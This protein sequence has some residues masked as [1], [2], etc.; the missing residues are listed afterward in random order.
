MK[1][2][3]KQWRIFS[4]YAYSDME[5]RFEKMAA[6]GWMLTKITNQ[7]FYYEKAEPAKVKFTVTYFAKASDF[8][9]EIT[10]EQKDFNDFCAAAGWE[11]VSGV[12]QMQV[13]CNRNENPVPIETDPVVQVNAIHRAMKK[14]FIPS[15]ILILVLSIFVIASQIGRIRINPV[16]AL[17]DNSTLFASVMY[18]FMAVTAVTDPYRYLVWYKKARKR[19]EDGVWCTSA[20]SS[21]PLQFVVLAL[22]LTV[23]VIYFTS[24]FTHFRPVFL[25]TIFAI[26][27]SVSFVTLFIK[28]FLKKL[29]VSRYANMILTF[30]V[31]VVYAFV[32]M[33]FLVGY[34]LKNDVPITTDESQPVGT[35]TYMTMEWDLYRDRLPLYVED[36]LTPQQ[37]NYTE[38]SCRMQTDESVFLAIYNDRHHT[39]ADYSGDAPEISYEI[40]K[41]K[42]D[43]LYDMCFDY[44]YSD[45][46]LPYG[47]NVERSLQPQLVE[48]DTA[49]WQAEKAYRTVYDGEM[50]NR[51]L[52]CYKNMLVELVMSFELTDAQMTTVSHKLSEF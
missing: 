10:E 21:H 25:I 23:A 16:S 43:A 18:A 37:I 50:L 12:A 28:E 34:I 35:Y 27:G 49:P 32:A 9:P 13:Y 36:L 4:F 31:P 17:A 40:I 38:Y 8:D 24:E 52:I 14:N 1:N 7:F 30:T 41:V 48:I 6:E 46:H 22:V 51:W 20:K 44:K 33:G 5:A 45:M 29:K 26:M 2:T 11:Y 47:K 15:Y 3:K 19:A 42:S 39:R